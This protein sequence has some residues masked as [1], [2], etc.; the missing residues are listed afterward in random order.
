MKVRTFVCYKCHKTFACT[1]KP[2]HTKPYGN[3]CV[4]CSLHGTSGCH[5]T[6]RDLKRLF[7]LCPVCTKSFTQEEKDVEE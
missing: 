6:E 4:D 3:M 1:V 7:G 5:K 2:K